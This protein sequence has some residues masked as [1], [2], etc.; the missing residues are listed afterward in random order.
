ME[1]IIKTYQTLRA[2][3]ALLCCIAFA[4][5]ANANCEAAF[6]WEL[7]AG[8]SYTTVVFYN[9]STGNGYSVNWDFGDASF[10]SNTATEVT[11]LFDDFGYYTVTLTIWDNYGC[12]DAIQQV[13]YVGPDSLKCDYTDCVYPGDA[14]T[15]GKADMYDVL[16]LG[17]GMGM[18]GP[19]RANASMEWIGQPADDWDFNTD[20]N[21]N[22]KHFDF[23]GNGIIEAVDVLAV[24]QNN[25][26]MDKTDIVTEWNAPLVDVRFHQDTIEIEDLFSNTV[27]AKADIVLGE[28]N[29]PFENLYGI[30]FYVK[31][32]AKF[33]GN[34]NIIVTPE[35]SFLN[36][37]GSLGDF[38]MEW[39]DRRPQEQVEIA[40]TRT[41]GLT[42]NGNGAVAV[43]NFIVVSDL[44]L[45]VAAPSVPV[46]LTI[47]GVKAIDNT[48]KELPVRLKGSTPKVIFKKVDKITPVRSIEE[49]DKEV[50]I[51]P[52]PA[53]DKVQIEFGTLQVENIQVYN[54][55]GELLIEEVNPMNNSTIDLG[56]FNKGVYII[57]LRI[58][59]G[60]VTRRVVVR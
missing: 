3:L 19:V 48:G 39:Q 49:A 10:S 8:T 52:N 11:H 59:E 33:F 56:Q 40:L 16:Y 9:N 54:T 58:E 7:Q 50:H 42:A 4:Y 46:E 28:E 6:E 15:D 27:S 60:I 30:A 2:Y 12:D 1:K 14:N 47:E 36:A 20:D 13:I 34:Q 37:G 26:V 18:E 29:V 43:I 22:Y 21:I 5:T 57:N 24:Y 31:Y 38:Q 41:D 53:T 17:M 32:P 25:S 23:D 55:L 44:L 51:F 35:S 45:G